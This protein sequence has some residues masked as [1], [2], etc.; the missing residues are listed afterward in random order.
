MGRIYPILRGLC[1]SQKDSP[2]RKHDGEN[3]GAARCALA[4]HKP[5]EQPHTVL[6][7]EIPKIEPCVAVVQERRELPYEVCRKARG[8]TISLLP[9]S[10]GAAA[11]AL[12]A[13]KHKDPQ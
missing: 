5:S 8:A 2:N 1:F 6:Q 9:Q 3:A 7:S 12:A 4:A 10:Q 13:Q 11:S